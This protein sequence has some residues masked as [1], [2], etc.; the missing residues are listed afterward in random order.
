M[1]EKVALAQLQKEV[2]Y[3]AV[4]SGGPGGQH[5]NKTATK[6]ELYWEM[7]K[8]VALTKEQK[9]QLYQKKQHLF[10]KNWVLKLTCASARSQ[11]RNKKLVTEKFQQ[12]V[13]EGVQKPKKRRKTK[14]TKAAKLKRLHEKK[15]RSALKNTR[16]KKNFLE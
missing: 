1:K 11:H 15:K 5:V 14:P 8:S 3:K 2:T 10:S 4:L 16:S 6:V 12:L 7:D 13:E 9:H